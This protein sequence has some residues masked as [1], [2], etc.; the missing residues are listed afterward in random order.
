MVT[1][2]RDWQVLSTSLEDFR[3]FAERLVALKDSAGVVVF[4]PEAS[5]L[6][7][8]A[9]LP[10]EKRLEISPALPSK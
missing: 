10:E 4:G 5:L 9:A 6:A 2:I 3:F 1:F 7:A 8:N